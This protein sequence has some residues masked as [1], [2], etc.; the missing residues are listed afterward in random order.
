MTEIYIACVNISCTLPLSGGTCSDLWR[1]TKNFFGVVG[2][3][4]D[5]F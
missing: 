4:L 1:P 5:D 2:F 3:V